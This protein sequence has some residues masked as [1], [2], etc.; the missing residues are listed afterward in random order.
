MQPG[1]PGRRGDAGGVEDQTAERVGPPT[2]EVVADQ[3]VVAGERGA[4]RLGHPAF[5]ADQQWSG[6]RRLADPVAAQR[7]GLRNAELLGQ[8]RSGAGVHDLGQQVR[9]KL[10]ALG[11]SCCL[12]CGDVCL[13][14]AT[15]STTN[16]LQSKNTG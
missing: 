9:G 2:A 4:Q 5:A 11:A 13:V 6:Q 10:G 7:L 1:Q 14:Q 12:P 16:L 3:L 15:V 8:E